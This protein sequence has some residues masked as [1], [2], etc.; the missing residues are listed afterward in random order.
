VHDACHLISWHVSQAKQ[1]AILAIGFVSQKIYVSATCYQNMSYVHKIARSG[2]V[3]ATCTC[4]ANGL[5]TWAQ[6][7]SF[8]V[9]LLM[10]MCVAFFHERHWDRS[11]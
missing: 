8:R 2:F 3:L 10:A 9:S 4:A 5:K 11:S 1:S 6:L 7:F